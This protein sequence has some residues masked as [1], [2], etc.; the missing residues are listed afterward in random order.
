[1]NEK[2]ILAVDDW[3]AG[4]KIARECDGFFEDVEEEWLD[5]ERVSC[6]NCRYRRFMAEGINC[7]KSLFPEWV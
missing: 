1:M 7:M 2:R 3:Q 5:E 4:R 6:F